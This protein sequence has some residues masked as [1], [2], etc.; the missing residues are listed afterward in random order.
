MNEREL[1]LI[2]P[3]HMRERGLASTRGQGLKGGACGPGSPA[4]GMS[5]QVKLCGV[6][7]HNDSRV[8]ADP[9]LK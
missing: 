6:A 8:T 3:L 7:A 4:C 1:R 5:N 9:A 2:D